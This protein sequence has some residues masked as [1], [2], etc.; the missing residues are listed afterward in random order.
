MKLNIETTKD[1][2]KTEALKRDRHKIINTLH[3]GIEREERKKTECKD[4]RNR[5][6]QR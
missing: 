1:K 5:E 2:N 4:R 6:V 3:K